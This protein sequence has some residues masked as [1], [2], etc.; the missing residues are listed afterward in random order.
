[1]KKYYLMAIE[2]GC[3][4]AMFNLGYYYDKIEHNYEL[5][6]EYYS[7]AIEK[8]HT[9]SM[10]NLGYYYQTK[11][12]NYDLMKKYYLMCN[13]YEYIGVNNYII[14]SYFNYKSF[15]YYNL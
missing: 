13:K 11:H 7:M 14:R 9:K 4:D 5:M 10:F 2:K 3:L 6:K 15:N 1:M 12:Y 8:G